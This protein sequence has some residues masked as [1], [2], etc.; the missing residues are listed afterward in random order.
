MNDK[1]P[2]KP[3]KATQKVAKV[4][5]RR[6]KIDWVAAERDFR[7]G[8]YSQIELSKLHGMAEATLCRRIK[9]K[10]KNDTSRWQQDLI[11]AVR[12]ATNAALMND[13]IKSEV[14]EGQDKVK[15]SILVTAEL[16]KQVLLNHRDRLT[17]LADAVEFAKNVIIRVAE[18]VNDIRDA[19]TLAQAV[20]SL[21][22][23]TK[24]LIDKERENFKLN[25]APPD[26]RERESAI[27][28]MLAAI[29]RS[30]FPVAK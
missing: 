28:G 22:S 3:T 29:G 7:T 23:S 11:L 19:A 15:T 8:K 12:Q 9:A 14:N 26:D 24:T 20:N 16:N 13:L 6:V 5:S 30:A 21:A 2:A 10:K 25:D 4:V 27:A 17:G 1:T 18:N